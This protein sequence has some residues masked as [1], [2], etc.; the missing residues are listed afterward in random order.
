MWCDAHQG[1]KRLETRKVVGAQ[2]A[3]LYDVMGSTK[4]F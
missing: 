1:V 4:G 3:G 2:A